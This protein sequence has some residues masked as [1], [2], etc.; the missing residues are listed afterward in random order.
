M[1]NW[2]DRFR[3][4]AQVG[5][6]AAKK[7]TFAAALL[8]T[9]ALFP[10]A[11]HAADPVA[12]A[13]AD[14]I[15]VT[16][17]VGKDAGGG[18]MIE[19][20]GP[21]QR[22]TV[23]TDFIA[24]QAPTSNP[25]QLI[26]LLPGANVSSSDAF[27][28][29][30]SDVTIRGMSSKQIGFMLEGA[31]L[32][33]SGSFAIYP[34]EF[35]DSENLATITLTQGSA[36]LGDP[37]TYA[38]GGTVNIAMIDPYRNFGVTLGESAGTHA[39]FRSYVRIDS[40]DVDTGVAGDWRAFISGSYYQADH[41]TGPGQDSRGHLDFK[42]VDEW[43]DGN[44][45]APVVIFNE[46]VL[47]EYWGASKAQWQS[48]GQKAVDYPSTL[49]STLS[50]TAPNT[51][52]YYYRLKVNPFD[53]VIASMPST[54]KL[55]NNITYEVTPYFWY[56][57]GNGGAS[58]YVASSNTIYYGTS[59]IVLQAPF[60]TLTI[61]VDKVFYAPSV[62]ETYRPGLNNRITWQVDTQKI[63]LGYWIEYAA[64]HQWEPLGYVEP[65]GSP[66]DMWGTK[67][68]LQLPNNLGPYTA[69]NE[70]AYTWNQTLFLGDEISLWDNR[71]IIDA[72][73]KEG[74]VQR[75]ADN[76]ELYVPDTAL[77]P[78]QQIKEFKKET[79]PFFS[80]RYKIDRDNTLLANFAT[81]F[82][83]PNTFPTLFGS[84]NNPG[85]SA[86]Y[87]LPTPNLKDERSNT[88]EIGWRYQTALLDAAV[89]GFYYDFHDR[90]ATI[91]VPN[92][93]ST[94]YFTNDI[95]IGTTH[96]S[97]VDAEIGLH[98]IYHWRPYIS[99]E[100]LTTR[101]ESN[102]PGTGTLGKNFD[103][104]DY[105]PTMGKQVPRA[106][107]EQFGLGI[108]Y[109]DRHI[110]GNLTAK[111]VGSQYSTYMNDESMPAHATADMTLGYRFPT[112]SF[113]Q[114]PEFRLNLI[115]LTNARYLSGVG[116][117]YSNAKTQTG[118]YGSAISGTAPYYTVGA[119][120]SAML[121]FT[122]KF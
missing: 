62:T 52:A 17:V 89:T 93:T 81:N 9:T 96:A 36:D 77:W 107:N 32:N 27:G 8:G 106:P 56:G 88:Y 10:I 58:Y 117:V 11:A 76:H 31:P 23:T 29:Q 101:L 18:L 86:V 53:D 116:G 78:S 34:S 38:T 112:V 71:L 48:E 65:S 63:Y 87:D 75:T 94:D 69:Y 50:G 79:L 26:T 37:L 98:P 12:D 47:G 44:R 99:A 91:N 70:T 4:T 108:S 40:G 20:D 49:L 95:N 24:T 2:I 61:G 85:S 120:F 54:F 68:L 3:L 109:D 46:G 59:K 28:I 42:A 80:A 1:R 30:Q 60:N 118:I 121:T 13:D 72:G 122:T 104:A 51:A 6:V 83:V 21:K 57:F 103:F 100:Y 74:F 19:E 114:G 15:T 110:F 33:D 41:W 66:Y 113:L 7:L 105:L 82:H 119:P 14:T 55:A 22:S 73:V 5:P 84:I 45:I 43:G 35:I 92:V 90:Q 67:D 25:V 102:I 111:Y 64:Q 39:A 115:N 97:G 16:G